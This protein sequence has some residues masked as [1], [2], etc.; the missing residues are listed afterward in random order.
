MKYLK[1]S[2]FFGFI[3]AFFVVSQP[4]AREINSA[5]MPVTGKA[6]PPIGHVKFCDANPGECELQ[7]NQDGIMTLTQERWDE[8]IRINHLVNQSVTAVTDMDLYA[9]PE[10][11]A[12]PGKYGDCEDF[13]LLKRHFL[14]QAGW[15]AGSLLMTVALDVDGGGH[16]VLTVKTD[17]GD[18][19]LDNL[20]PLVKNWAD[21]PYTYLKRQ[22][23]KHPAK[24]EAVDNAR[25]IVPTLTA[26]TE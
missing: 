16:A 3:V 21:T 7:D 5:F 4:E 17:R 25:H 22:S 24:W 26:S 14:M 6:R 9:R 8:L 23:S 10:V 12:F 19:I 11:W 2:L 1:R 13:A 15:P 20:E 18:F